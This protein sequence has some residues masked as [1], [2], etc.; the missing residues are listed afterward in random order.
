MAKADLTLALSMEIDD[1]EGTQDDTHENFTRVYQ[2][3]QTMRAEGL[4]VPKDLAALEK[5]WET[6]SK[7]RRKRSRRQRLWEPKIQM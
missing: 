4:P 3:L 2:I 6:A 1:M 5:N 7:P